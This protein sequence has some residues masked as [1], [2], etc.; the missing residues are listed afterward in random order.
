MEKYCKIKLQRKKRTRR[1]GGLMRHKSLWS[2]QFTLI[3][4]LLVIAIIAILA[5][6]LLPV[7]K[8]AREKAKALTCTNSLKQFGIAHVMYIND[9]NGFWAAGIKNCS[10]S[11][12]TD[13]WPSKLYPYISKKKNINYNEQK[14]SIWFCPSEPNDA[15]PDNAW[16]PADPSW[17]IASDGIMRDT[18]TVSGKPEA[19]KTRD[20]KIPSGKAYLTE[21]QRHHSL[22]RDLVLTDGGTIRKLR[23]RHSNQRLANVLFL[24]G[25]SRGYGSPPMQGGY[26]GVSWNDTQKR[27]FD[28]TYNESPE[29]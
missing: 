18:G 3:E 12:I 5:A 23:Q 16:Y 28:I 4:L 1:L 19:Y 22:V 21:T 11:T 14:N 24:D 20:C 15:W 17:G 26:V 25:H 6:I 2:T 13:N 10:Y 7:L 9:Y 8:T 29:L 27:W